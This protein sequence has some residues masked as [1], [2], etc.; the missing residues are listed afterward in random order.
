MSTT[1]L[2]ADYEV[3]ND[4]K[5]E[6]PGKDSLPARVFQID[7]ASSIWA[8]IGPGERHEVVWCCVLEPLGV[9]GCGV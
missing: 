3:A 6:S 8:Q 1:L 2:T 7:S 4:K 9:F 5:K